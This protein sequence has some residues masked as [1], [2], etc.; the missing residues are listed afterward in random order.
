M[1]KMLVLVFLLSILH[2][3]LLASEMAFRVRSVDEDRQPISNATVRL[4]FHEKDNSIEKQVIGA[5]DS[6]GI[7]RY[8]GSYIGNET[9]WDITKPGY[10]ESC[11][12]RL[13]FSNTTLIF[14]NALLSQRAGDQFSS[15]L[16]NALESLRRGDR[17]ALSNSLSGCSSSMQSLHSNDPV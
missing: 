2:F 5:T 7:W 3:S 8:Q 9:S 11:G 6:N 15:A 17:L 13:V 14:A 16:T 12:D 10:Y 1:N 4:Q